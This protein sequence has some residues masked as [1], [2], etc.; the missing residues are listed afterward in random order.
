M[1]DYRIE[2]L[3]KDATTGG[4]VPGVLV[5]AWD[6]DF[7]TDDLVGSA[8]TDAQGRFVMEFE[9]SYF[10]ELFFDNRPDLYF[11]VFLG[12][13]LVLSTEDDIMW[14]VDAGSSS[15][16]LPVVIPVEAKVERDIYLCIER[17]EDYNPV[18]PAE[19][20]PANV[21]YKRDCMRFPGHPGGVI[22]DAE[23]QARSVP[24]VIYREYL[25]PAYLVP[26]IDK[27]VKADINEPS[28]EHRVPGTVIYA[29][30]NEL[31]R[32]HVKNRDNKPHSL[33]THGVLFGIDSDGAWPFG[34]QA[35][36]G[37]R[38]DEICPGQS[39]TYTF[40]ATEET[41]GVWPFHDHAQMPG[42]AID[43]GLFGGIVVLPKGV[44]KP[45][46]KPF[47]PL[48]DLQKYVANIGRIALKPKIQHEIF[49]QREWIK[50]KF[51]RE[52]VL[53]YPR[54]KILHVPLFF[55]V[56]KTPNQR[57]VFD[58]GDIG[59]L[60]GSASL[61]F[62]DLGE[63]EYFCV[64]HP[65][66]TGKVRVEVGEPA[67][68]SVTIEDAPDMGFF[69]E[70]IAVAPGGTVTWTNNSQFH[71]TVTSKDGAGINTHCL[72]GRGFV[73]NSPTVVGYQGQKIRWYVFNLDIGHEFH[74]FHPHSQRW[75]LAGK[76]ID[77]RSLSPA[78]SFQVETKVPPVL[79]LTEEMEAI[80]PK[81]KRPAHAKLYRLKGDFVFHCHVH[82]HMM[83]G[84]IGIVRA[85][86]NVWLTPG[87]VD[88]IETRTGL[89]IDDFTNK[90]PDVDPE[91]CKKMS[92]GRIE[93]IAA[94]PEVI[95]MHAALLPQSD[96]VI[97]WG[98]TRNDSSRIFDAATNTFSLPV[99]Q[100][101]DLPGETANSSDL[102]SAG[103]IHL[104]SPNGELL[105]HGGLSEDGANDPNKVYIF[106][107]A[108]DTWSPAANTAHGRF[109]PTTLMR[110][111]GNVMT[112]YG[113][114]GPVPISDTFEIYNAVGDSWSAPAQ[115][116]F[117]YLYY[118][119][120]YVLPDGDYFIAGP[121]VPAR[122]VDF[123][124]APPIPDPVARQF[125]TLKGGR[126][127]N[128]NGTSVLLPLRGPGYEPTVMIMGGAPLAVRKSVQAISPSAVSP[129]WNDLSNLNEERI[130][131]TSVLLP[132]GRVIVVGGIF[133]IPGGGPIETYDPQNPGD[134]WK[135]GPESAYPRLYHSSM[136]LLPDA[137]VLIGG[138]DD[139]ADP[140]ERYFPEY[141]D[142]PRLDILGMSST[143]VTWG[144]NFT[145]QVGAGNPV[146]EVVLMRPGAVTHGFDMSQR[147]VELDIVGG[148]GG[149]VDV[150]APPN[151]QIA[152]PGWHLLFVLDGDRIPCLKGQW[153]RLTGP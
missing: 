49:G 151:A 59:E 96:R 65:S 35:A 75:Q 135:I 60:G 120:M 142:M 18:E 144:E 78:E 73:G 133:G 86:Q 55:H 137:S 122:K 129:T 145:I 80:Q 131:C 20:V 79:L 115:A 84:M 3:V 46:T 70:D 146:A 39:W 74:N 30:P 152:P 104:D 119:W 94:P 90:C 9:D 87:M 130:N 136:I 64:Y 98:K 111:D 81:D 13:D 31:L 149:N 139:G 118:P 95:M 5:E 99:N 58:T 66:M 42:P 16:T 121:Q 72:N 17:I 102:W 48:L 45:Y 52:L 28:Y 68:A 153:I 147:L 128:M 114:G 132:D 103:H 40:C 43:S 29:H 21:R 85:R 97:I 26:K 12:D 47:K 34:T 6:K 138:D 109:Y 67:A 140:C 116:S 76:N 27:L 37:R 91:R 126:G 44:S 108:T 22:P 150:A 24:A 32:I 2:G 83:N 105:A 7:F 25:D 53:V 100:P 134:G 89:P 107:P 61:T 77:V 101:A 69:P 14:N 41:V 15:V 127:S 10:Q 62:D 110:P 82:H 124:V 54:D 123:S 4:P 148:A 141:Y 51:Q 106:D 50:E 38:S 71:H 113:N 88:D 63:F 92:A 56:M 33:H 143:Q 112:Y 125:D 117:N 8:T 11:M 57:P 36:D 1:A 23:V 93:E 19:H